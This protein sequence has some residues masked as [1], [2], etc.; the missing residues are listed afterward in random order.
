MTL[1]HNWQG[2][3]ETNC[4]CRLEGRE[5]CAREEP[6]VNIQASDRIRQLL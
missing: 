4:C 1:G 2:P 3:T 6:K 5:S